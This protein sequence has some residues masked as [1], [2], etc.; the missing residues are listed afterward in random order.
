MSTRDVFRAVILAAGK[1]KRMKSRVSKIMHDVLGKPI[2]QYVVEAVQIPEV[3]EILVVVGPHNQAEVKGILGNSVRYVLQE[4]QLGTAH[5]LQVCQP[6]LKD[7]HGQLLVLVGDAPF[8]TREVIE[9]LVQ[10]HRAH[11][12][13]AATLLTAI[14]E[15]PPP[16]GR[17]VRDATGRVIKIVEDKDADEEIKKIREVST[18]H[19]AFDA[20]IVLPLLKEIKNDN[21]QGEYYLPDVIEL[22]IQKG[23]NVAA[24]PVDDPFT[25]FGIN[26]R[27]DLIRGIAEMRKR[28]VRRWLDAG[29]TILDPETTFI[30][31]TVEIGTDTVIYPFTHLEKHTRIGENCRIG[32]F[33]YLSGA[34]VPDGDVIVGNIRKSPRSG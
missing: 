22:L 17:V 34:Y 24:L 19:Y 11:T 18:S 1:S 7:Y 10:Y 31:T 27:Q 20:D 14:Y 12:D 33:V 21:A 8:L 4:E 5:A 15:T 25:T 6:A 26:T 13:V 16:Y 29:V 23:H 30:D 2:I 3:E 9:K 32:P 28:I